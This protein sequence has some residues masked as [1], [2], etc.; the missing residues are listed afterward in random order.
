MASFHSWTEEEKQYLA[1]ITPGHHYKE[2]QQLVNQ[3]F[4]LNLT[5]GQIKGAIG[6]YKLNTGFTGQFQKGNR[7]WN[8]GKKGVHGTG[9]EKT[10]FTKGHKPHNY[11]PVGSERVNG[12]GY[13]EVK[14]KNPGTWKGKHILIWEQY[15]GPVPPNHVVIFGD[16]DKTNLD[17]NNLVLV[18]RQQLLTLNRN[19]LIK[20]NVE[21]TK[22]GVIIADLYQKINGRK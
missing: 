1:N 8:K 3:K 15:N 13:I 6:R 7:S 9:C 4:N 20:N 5:L 19:K 10:W 22:T 17:I 11:L 2:I 21:L 14:I 16:R 18:S 12:D